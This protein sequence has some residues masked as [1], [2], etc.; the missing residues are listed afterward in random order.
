MSCL[1]P[2]RR[3]NPTGEQRRTSASRRTACASTWMAAGCCGCSRWQGHGKMPCC[4][5]GV[6]PQSHS[7]MMLLLLKSSACLFQ[8]RLGSPTKRTR[9]C[10]S[11]SATRPCAAA[12]PS[13]L[14]GE[15]SSQRQEPAPGQ[16]AAGGLAH[17]LAVAAG[18]SDERLGGNWHGQ[19]LVDVVAAVEASRTCSSRAAAQSPAF[20]T[21]KPRLQGCATPAAGLA[22][23]CASCAQ[24]RSFWQCS[25]PRPALRAIWAA[26]GR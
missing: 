24:H 8:Q 15:R 18:Q 11:P 10:A 12:L 21:D 26:I 3:R 19:L 2:V 17:H 23:R 16:A 25:G 5:P 1:P 20:C 14:K 22:S 4:L 9:S 7:W 6:P 13:Q